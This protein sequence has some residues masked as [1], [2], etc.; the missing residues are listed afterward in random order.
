MSIACLLASLRDKLQRVIQLS[1]A[2]V[3]KP[4]GKATGGRPKDKMCS[5]GGLGENPGSLLGCGS[6]PLQ[7]TSSTEMLTQHKSDH[8]QPQ[9][10]MTLIKDTELC[11][12]PDKRFV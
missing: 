3:D 4:I 10:D 5:I 12:I 11:S 8:T 9:P 1:P 7:M 6:L 2:A